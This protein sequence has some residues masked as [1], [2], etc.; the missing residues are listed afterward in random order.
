MIVNDGLSDEMLIAWL[1]S[2]FD[3]AG[4]E[5]MPFYL[6]W[7]AWC[8]APNLKY[9]QGKRWHTLILSRGIQSA[10]TT[11]SVVLSLTG[12][13]AIVL[14]ILTDDYLNRS[15][16]HHWPQSI[17]ISLPTTPST[18]QQLYSCRKYNLTGYMEE[19]Y[20]KSVL[21]LFDEKASSNFYLPAVVTPPPPA[22]DPPSTELCSVVC[23]SNE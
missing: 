21:R 6:C 23:D 15:L 17:Q 22:C 11:W 7:V 16:H 9:I 18:I 20:I 8:Q 4:Y 2:S 12:F 14:N 1:S 5:G 13:K 10:V 3:S 19:G